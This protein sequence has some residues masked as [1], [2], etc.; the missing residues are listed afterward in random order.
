MSETGSRK[1]D[2][3]VGTKLDPKLARPRLKE[4]LVPGDTG[5]FL[6]VESGA[7]NGEVLSFAS[8]GTWLIGREGADIVVDDEKISRKHAELSLLGPGAWF[9]RDLASTNGTFVN[10]TRVTEKVAI[11]SGNSIRVGD[12]LF[13]FYVV[14]GSIVPAGVR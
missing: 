12:T 10:G 14:A 8:G 1:D 13:G 2:A 5:I 4:G 6:R 3:G 9:I 7:R 11:R